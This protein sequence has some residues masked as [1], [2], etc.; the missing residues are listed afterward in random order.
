M[1]NGINNYNN[2]YAEKEKKNVCNVYTIILT[3]D[4]HCKGNADIV[5]YR[6]KYLLV[7]PIIDC[8]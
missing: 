7:F 1:Y 2:N 6:M 5:I 3:E 4:S 8:C